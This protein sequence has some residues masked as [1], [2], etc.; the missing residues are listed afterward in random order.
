VLVGAFINVIPA[1]GEELG[2]R[3]WLLPKRMPLGTVP[4]LVLSGI[5]WGI[6]HAP[7]VLLRYPGRTERMKHRLAAYSP[8]GSDS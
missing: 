6:W 8:F 7:L 2:W 4:A 5:I 3:G 1:I